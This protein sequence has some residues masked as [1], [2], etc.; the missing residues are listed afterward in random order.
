MKKFDDFYFEGKKYNLTKELF[1]YRDTS[2]DST[3][4]FIFYI[5]DI[6]K[7]VC[8]KV[9]KK[10]RL[11]K[12]GHKT[13]AQFFEQV[14]IDYK[15]HPLLNL[16]LLVEKSCF[17]FECIKFSCS[18]QDLVKCYEDNLNNHWRNL[19]ESFTL[20]WNISYEKL[21]SLEEKL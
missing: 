1:V 6:Q 21:F 8:L 11:Y 15:D 18:K 12:D 13:M 5:Y 14:V 16:S 17:K 20:D 7:F 9:D 4:K 3:A 2:Y 10:L 19:S